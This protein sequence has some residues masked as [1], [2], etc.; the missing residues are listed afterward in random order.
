MDLILDLVEK[1]LFFFF[2][3]P[4]TN[5]TVGVLSSQYVVIS[6]RGTD[7]IGVRKP[8]FLFLFAELFLTPK[9]GFI[10]DAQFEQTQ[11]PLAPS[12][13]RCHAGF[14]KMVL[15][16]KV[17]WLLGFTHGCVRYVCFDRMQLRVWSPKHCQLAHRARCCGRDTL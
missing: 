17:K 6:W 9:K 11:F 2:R 7:N 5:G 15:S 12:G 1:S 13:A 8:S 3:C 10:G 16:N 14:L 4:D